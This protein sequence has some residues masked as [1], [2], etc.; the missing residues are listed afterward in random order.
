[1]APCTGRKRI[2]RGRIGPYLFPQIP[3]G[4]YHRFCLA[5]IEAGIYPSPDYDTP[6]IIPA[7]FEAGEVKK[8][9]AMEALWITES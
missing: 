9:D 8:L 3:R 5:L 4:E 1:M 7:E 2:L 6:S